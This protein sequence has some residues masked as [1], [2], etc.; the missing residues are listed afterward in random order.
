MVDVAVAFLTVALIII[1]GYFGMLFFKK[2]KI[3]ELIIL[4]IIG[5]II[6]P[7]S[8]A[9]GIG[10]IGPNELSIFN[11][12]LPFFAA[13]ALIMILFEGG[14]QLNFFKALKALTNALGFTVGVFVL[15]MLFTVGA[16]WFLSL[17]GLIVFDLLLSLFIGAII[18]GTSSAVIIPIV[19]STSARE[20][21]KTLLSLESALTDALCIVV[22]VA[23]GHI[24]AFGSANIPTVASGIIANFTIAAVIG[25]VA[26]LVWLKALSYFDGKAYS[27]LMTLAA[28]LLVYSLVQIVGGN[29]AIAILVF[30]IVL[31]NSIDITK[32]LQLEERT[33]DVSIKTFH[34]ELSFLVKTF[35]FVYL[36][37]LFRLEFAT[38]PIILISIVLVILIW[39]SRFIIANA[40]GKLKPIFRSDSKL[41]SMMSA[42]GLAAAV[43]VSLPVSMGLDK[44]PNTL[45]TPELI[46]TITAIA[47]LVILL[48]NIS[49]T[50]G[51]FMSETAMTKM[52]NK[53]A[54]EGMAIDIADLSKSKKGKKQRKK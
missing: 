41:I 47:F 17:S 15:G 53:L 30:G 6:G 35:F 1:V 38:P 27:Y 44:L 32:M 45:F 28:L 25:F 7:I 9:L 43:L 54:T 39:A 23:I 3:S 34:S 42:R 33:I 18:G 4:M 26:G 37:I 10:I 46:G 29:G 40:L 52:K 48:S 19:H 49:T 50:I 2:T 22:A 5:L 20:E 12:F 16:I 11:S 36:G 24:F 21:T 13:F 14:M 31:G 51:V 8:S